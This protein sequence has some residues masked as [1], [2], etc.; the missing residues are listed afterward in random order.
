M[1]RLFTISGIFMLLLLSQNTFAQEQ[2]KM[3]SFTFKSDKTKRNLED[4]TTIYEGNVMIKNDNISFENAEK[5]IHNP[6]NGTYTIYHPENF[7]IIAAK[8]VHK[9]G[10]KEDSHVIIYNYKEESITF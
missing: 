4:K 3:K 2:S 5:V 7:K 8:S 9:T 1:K 10:K 6:E